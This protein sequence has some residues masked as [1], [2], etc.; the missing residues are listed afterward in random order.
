MSSDWPMSILPKKAVTR[1]SGATATQ[2]SSSV[3]ER[4]GLVPP[5]AACASASSKNTGPAAVTNSAPEALRNSRR[6]RGA[7]MVVSSGHLRLGALDCAQDGN[8]RPAAALESRER[9]AQL[10]VAR[11]GV[12]LQVRGRG[13]DPAVDAIAALRHLLLD[14]RRLQRVG[15]L[16]RPQ[17]LQRCDL[18]ACDRG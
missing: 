4:G 10:S 18:L 12:L 16:R 11:L 17:A 8:V 14:V 2:E 15:L 13:H 9:V 7:F 6:E 1:P 5:G 3:G